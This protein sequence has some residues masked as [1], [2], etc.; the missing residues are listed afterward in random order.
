MAA[1]SISPLLGRPLLIEGSGARE[2]GAAAGDSPSNLS[3]GG[4]ESAVAAPGI[5]GELKMLGILVSER[6]V[7]R[8]TEAPVPAGR[9]F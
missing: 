8:A 9:L 7:S 3:D 5:H 4:R 6:T 2:A 1:G